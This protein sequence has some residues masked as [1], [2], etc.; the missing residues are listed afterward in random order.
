MCAIYTETYFCDSLAISWTQESFSSKLASSSLPFVRFRVQGV[1]LLPALFA[2]GSG[3]VARLTLEQ[4]PQTGSTES[5]NNSSSSSGLLLGGLLGVVSADGEVCVWDLSSLVKVGQASLSPL[6]ASSRALVATLGASMGASTGAGAA[7]GAAASSAASASSS[8]RAL[9]GRRSDTATATAASPAPN[10]LTADL[11]GACLSRLE[12][13]IVGRGPDDRPRV[14]VT[15]LSVPVSTAAAQS[16]QS[17]SNNNDNNGGRNNNYSVGTATAATTSTTTTT[18]A[19]NGVP[20]S[21]SRSGTRL[22]AFGLHCGLGAWVRLADARF[23]ASDFFTVA[24]PPT[25]AAAAPSPSLQQPQ[26]NALSN[27]L[28]VNDLCTACNLSEQP[29]AQLQWTVTSAP[30]VSRPVAQPVSMPYGQA[31]MSQIGG[32][33][34]ATLLAL[35]PP[36]RSS[37]SGNNSGTHPP[38]PAPMP[39]A[40]VAQVSAL[41]RAGPWQR[42]ATQAHLEDRIA[43]ASALSAASEFQHWLGVGVCISF[44]PSSIAVHLFLLI[45]TSHRFSAVA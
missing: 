7:S 27:N 44:L 38:P 28:S 29:L 33:S 37:S 14:S 24:P 10:N 13:L 6:L 20:S 12:A 45:Y 2:P 34:A 30:P 18:G 35:E 39:A 31:G 43:C 32:L 25:I 16:E 4:A 26:S 3:G 9:D 40:L 22:E 23:A 11:S 15:I 19:G 1:R 36:A 42:L 21:Q 5:G 8:A 17:S 41:A